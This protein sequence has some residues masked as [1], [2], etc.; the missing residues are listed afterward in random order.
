MSFFKA[1]TL[2]WE[3][4]CYVNELFM[5]QKRQLEKSTR[6]NCCEFCGVSNKKL[7]AKIS[8]SKI[9]FHENLLLLFNSWKTQATTVFTALY[10]RGDFSRHCIHFLKGRSST[11]FIS[12]LWTPGIILVINQDHY[13]QL[14]LQDWQV[15]SRFKCFSSSGVDIRPFNKIMNKDLFRQNLI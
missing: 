4:W 14:R 1:D 6:W 3:E 9:N 12:K 8:P 2:D 10:C 7:T 13:A 11:S 5:Y 15:N